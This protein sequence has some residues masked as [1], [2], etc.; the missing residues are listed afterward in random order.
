MARGEDSYPISAPE[1]SGIFVMGKKTLVLT[2][3]MHVY[4]YKISSKIYYYPL[5][6]FQVNNKA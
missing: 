4:M 6:D 3:F 5:P 2:V 1:Q